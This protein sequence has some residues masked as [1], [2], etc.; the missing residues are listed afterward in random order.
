MDLLA[1]TD[2][3]PVSWTGDKLTTSHRAI[4]KG[5][6]DSKRQ[7]INITFFTR[8]HTILAPQADI[9]HK[10]TVCANYKHMSSRPCNN[11]VYI[12]I[13]NKHSLILKLFCDQGS[14]CGCDA[15]VSIDNWLFISQLSFFFLTPL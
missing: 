3:A 4:H 11:H 12:H 10:Y 6:G 13:L 14:L 15:P 9:Q 7:M 1:H 8:A 5:A 2:T